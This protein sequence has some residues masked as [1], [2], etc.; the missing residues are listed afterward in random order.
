MTSSNLISVTILLPFIGALLVALLPRKEKGLLKACAVGV[1]LLPL[2]S[3]AILYARF[4][5]SVAGFQFV[6]SF[7]WA[8]GGI[9]YIVGLDGI[10]I[11]LFMLTTFLTPLVILGAWNA[12]VDREKEFLIAMLMLEV[13]MLGAF[14]ALDLFLF[15]VFWEFMLI[16]MYLIIGVWGGKRRIY[17]AVKFFLYTMVGS[18]LMLVGIIYLYVKTGSS[19]FSFLEILRLDLSLKEQLLLFGAFGLAFAIKVPLFPFHTWLPDA[20]VE[21]PT[22]GSVILAGVLL[23]LG[24][25]GFL[26]FAIPMFPDAAGYFSVPL[27]GLSVIGIVY[28]AMMA[29]AQTDIKKLVAYSSVS[30]L[31]FVMLGVFAMN[32]ESVQGAIY[33]MVNHGISTGALFL[34]VGM[35]Y[36]R[37]HTRQIEDYGGI[38][39]VVPIY[40]TMFL[41]VTLSSIGL[42]A[43]NG[44]IG[45]FLILAGTFQ[46]ALG[47]SANYRVVMFVLAITAASGVV[48]GA[49]YM[50]TMYRR[51]FFGEVTHAENKGLK[52]MNLREVMVML[53]LIALIFIMGLVPGLFLDKTSASVK[54]YIEQW[55]PRV[56][57]V[58]DANKPP[59]AAA[60][61]LILPALVE[62]ASPVLATGLSDGEGV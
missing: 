2:I 17:A 1:S 37:R 7:P 60:G 22:P 29:F 38:A 50:L 5:A 27:M 3:S 18:L 61:A 54:A 11:L 57:Q 14:V 43:T 34:L 6:E 26:R 30:H 52:D 13:G 19:S 21:A 20:H 59:A 32:A 46:E 15:Y 51:V 47:G 35:I 24:T 45:E 9:Q 8:V 48:L 39:K 40:A 42:P 4:D 49:V 58:R 28:G 33:Q 36:E 62:P 16:P 56:E 23:K 41:I 10:S 44:F 12:I 53:P 25:Y 55:R 31:G